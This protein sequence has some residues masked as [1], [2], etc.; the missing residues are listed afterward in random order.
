MTST[1]DI[2]EALGEEDDAPLSSLESKVWDKARQLEHA[3]VTLESLEERVRS[4]WNVC[5]TV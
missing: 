2:K 5:I 1:L 3:S 4:C